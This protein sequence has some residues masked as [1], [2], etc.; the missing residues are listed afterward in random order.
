MELIRDNNDFVASGPTYPYTI[1]REYAHLDGISQK[2]MGYLEG[3]SLSKL[4]NNQ[5]HTGLIPLK[6]TVHRN[7]IIVSFNI[8][9]P[10]LVLDT[11]AVS[12]SDNYGFS[13]ITPNNQ[14]IL[15]KTLLYNNKIY[16]ICS[17]TPTKVKVRY[18]V[19]GAYWKSGNKH[20]PRGNLR[21]SQGDSY[22]CKINN[23]IYRIDNWCYLFDNVL[24]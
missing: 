10:P 18:A 22:K 5:K 6:T 21:D 13:V 8:P 1:M 12:K 14:N 20:G 7:T 11:I 17:K 4:L 3:I 2:R 24:N 16:L 9:C 23:K 15:K 19:N